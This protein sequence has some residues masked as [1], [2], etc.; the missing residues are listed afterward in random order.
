MLPRVALRLTPRDQAAVAAIAR[1]V[2][3]SLT[4]ILRYALAAG[5]E[6]ALKGG[7]PTQAIGR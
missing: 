4:N 1:L 3:P 5:H 7:E 2:G 6:A